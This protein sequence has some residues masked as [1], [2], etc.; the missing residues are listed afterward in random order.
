M[1]VV[2]LSDIS[3]K[4]HKITFLPYKSDIFWKHTI[5]AASVHHFAERKKL[6]QICK[7]CNKFI[8]NNK[9]QILQKNHSERQYGCFANKIILNGWGR[10]C[11][12]LLTVSFKLPSSQSQ[13]WRHAKIP[14]NKMLNKTVS[15]VF[16]NYRNNNVWLLV[17][18]LERTCPCSRSPP[19]VGRSGYRLPF[20]FYPL[21]HVSTAFKL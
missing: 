9:M 5:L 6:M 3:T 19:W 10:E 13:V 21:F 16:R 12:I 18:V 1:F 2:V 17:Q 20:S 8:W 15:N 4:D 11:L 7:F 14:R